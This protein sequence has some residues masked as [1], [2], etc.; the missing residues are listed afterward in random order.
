[1]CLPTDL[2]RKEMNNIEMGLIHWEM[3]LIHWEMGLIHREMMLIGREM[4]L[5]R[6]EILG[7]IQ[8]CSRCL[9]TF[10]LLT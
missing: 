7:Y 9:S 8:G 1:M 3:G 2:K 6:R 5:T 10:A 4:M